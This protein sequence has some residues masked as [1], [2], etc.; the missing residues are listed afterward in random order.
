[1][2]SGREPRAEVLRTSCS[3]VILTPG[4]PPGWLREH[5]RDETV[6]TDEQERPDEAK[7]PPKATGARFWGPVVGFGVVCLALVLVAVFV[8]I[9]GMRRDA[10]ARVE[11]SHSEAAADESRSAAAERE[12]EEAVEATASAQ[13]AETAK[14]AAAFPMEVT[15][16]ERAGVLYAG[17]DYEITAEGEFVVVEIALTDN[18]TEVLSPL[19]TYELIDA[20]TLIHSRQKPS[21]LLS[22]DPAK[23]PT[24]RE[25]APGENAVYQLIFDVPKGTEAASV[26]LTP[27]LPRQSSPRSTRRSRSDAGARRPSSVYLPRILCSTSPPPASQ[28]SP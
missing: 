23:E 14:A 13:A 4:T 28:I 21:G 6:E 24:M 15:G 12:S 3:L 2:R 25:L 9:G 20:D 19:S 5:E 26:K 27:V 16:V 11:A 18:S 10:V 1:M 17:T 8:V 7:M 22:T